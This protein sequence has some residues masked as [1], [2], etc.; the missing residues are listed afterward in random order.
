MC[1]SDLNTYLNTDKTMYV[2][3]MRDNSD[4]SNMLE[5]YGPGTDDGY[6]WESGNNSDTTL[7]N[8]MNGSN[9]NI[10]QMDSG[11]VNIVAHQGSV[12]LSSN[13]GFNVT[14]NTSVFGTTTVNG[15]TTINNNLTVTG[16]TNITGS[17]TISGATQLLTTLN[18]DGQSTLA[19]ANVENLT[20][21]RVVIVGINGQLEDDNNFTFD[22]SQLSVGAG[23]FTVQQSSGN[24]DTQGTLNVGGA[25]TLESTL[26]VT[27]SAN[28]KNN[29]I[30]SGTTTISGNTYVQYLVQNRVLLAGANGHIEDNN[31]LVFDTA[32]L[33]V[34]MEI[35]RAH[36]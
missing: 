16:N 10:L 15:A 5:L 4:D 23:N 26:D 11:N 36:V 29:V 9:T 28:F 6:W 27:G 13:N 2:S 22:G 19:S 20:N 35:G 8:W 1:S 32:K 33:Q 17:A 18:V 21:N 30:V 24:I 7:Y 14:G 3:R 34:G 12:N 31:N 25:T